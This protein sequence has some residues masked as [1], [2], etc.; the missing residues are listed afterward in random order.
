MSRR[1]IPPVF[2]CMYWCYGSVKLKNTSKT[3]LSFCE[4]FVSKAT[5]PTHITL[6]CAALGR[7]HRSLRGTQVAAG[8]LRQGA[9]GFLYSDSRRE[10]LGDWIALGL[11]AWRSERLLL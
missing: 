10:F 9:R 8:R 1:K 3:T 2:Q 4:F 7:P 5:K 6:V 11:A